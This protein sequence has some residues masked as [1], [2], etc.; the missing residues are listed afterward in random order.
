MNDT[1]PN[2]HDVVIMA[3]DKRQTSI[4]QLAAQA[5]GHGFAITGTTLGHIRARTYKSVP[6]DETVRALAWLAGVSE[7][8][9]FAAAGRRAP[10]P[11]LADELPPG[12]DNLSPKSRRAV[13]EL[14]R[15][16]V[17]AEERGGHG[18]AAP[19]NTAGGDPAGE[20]QD[21]HAASAVGHEMPEVE[22][23]TDAPGPAANGERIERAASAWTGK[24][25][26]PGGAGSRTPVSGGRAGGQEAEAGEQSPADFFYGLAADDRRTDGTAQRDAIDAAGEESQVPDEDEDGA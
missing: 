11:P 24:V 22:R 23:G 17:E 2:L 5:Q 20:Q 10:G 14:L 3:L 19:M 7:D 6:S 12:V 1:D 26:Q 9:A 15:V 4:R 18:E 21:P 8:V 13:I 16:L 25:A